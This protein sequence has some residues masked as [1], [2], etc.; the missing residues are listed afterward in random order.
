MKNNLLSKEEKE[1]KKIEHDIEILRLK[2]IE[3]TPEHFSKKDLINEFFG[4][5]IIGLTFIFKGGLVRTVGVIGLDRIMMI[6]IITFV[7]LIA[8]IYFIGYSRVKNRG[9]RRLGQFL[10][11]RLFSLYL[12]SIIVATMLVY[13]FGINILAGS[14]YEALKVVIVLT[15]P[16]AVGAAIPSLLKKYI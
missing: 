1:I 11:K 2:L 8:E 15:M 14:T 12:T 4:A 7:I 5:L 16:C 6:V 13:L 10:T 9:K 3:R